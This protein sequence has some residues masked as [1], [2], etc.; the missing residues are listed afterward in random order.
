VN[1]NALKTLN[2]PYT[3]KERVLFEIAG[4]NVQ[5]VLVNGDWYIPYSKLSPGKI[6][7]QRINGGYNFIYKQ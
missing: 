7:Y 4:L 3:D 2:V 1:W 5:A 6:T